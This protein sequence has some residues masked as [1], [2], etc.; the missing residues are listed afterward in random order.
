MARQNE[1]VS[2]QETDPRRH[3]DGLTEAQRYNTA[4]RPRRRQ[5]LTS[6]LSDEV[7]GPNPQGGQARFVTHVTKTLRKLAIRLPLSKQF[8]PSHVTRDVNVLERGHW[9]FSIGI[10]ES[11]MIRDPTQALQK[12]SHD[13]LV[14]LW[15]ERE[16]VQLWKNVCC[17]VQDGKAGWGTSMVKKQ[18]G[19]GL[20]RIRL[21]TWAEILGHIWLVLWVLSDKMMEHVPMHWIDGRGTAVITMSGRKPKGKG[22][23]AGSWVS[24]G[25]EGEQGYWGIQ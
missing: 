17:F 22:K 21:F 14:S 4:R 15:S 12:R 18:I 5:N 23:A 20:W 10:I 11:S 16:F 9:Q 24:K 8:R 1:E 13:E 2:Q 3:G 19:Q 7:H 25:P 6:Q